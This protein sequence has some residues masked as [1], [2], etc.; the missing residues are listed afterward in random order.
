MHVNIE[1]T[2]IDI[3]LP[4]SINLSFYSL[5]FFCIN[6]PQ[7]NKLIHLSYQCYLRAR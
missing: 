4:D 5:T 1:G 6:L 7:R 3:L 2:E